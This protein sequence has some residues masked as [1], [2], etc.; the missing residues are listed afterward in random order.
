MR[1]YVVRGTV[2]R[3]SEHMLCTYGNALN[4]PT[5]IWKLLP[6]ALV[7]PGPEP[8]FII[9]RV[10][11]PMDIG[12]FREVFSSVRSFLEVDYPTSPWDWFVASSG[13]ISDLYG[14]IHFE[15]HAPHYVGE[16]WYTEG[17]PCHELI[18]EYRARL[19][20]GE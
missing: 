16:K 13:G 2:E 6:V 12:T 17:C 18:A 1:W 14:S 3:S 11:V 10:P 20:R 8:T 9:E 19:E 5:P 4:P 7:A 15:P